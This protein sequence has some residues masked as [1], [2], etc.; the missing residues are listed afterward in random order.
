M[1]PPCFR[2]VLASDEALQKALETESKG[3]LAERAQTCG[4]FF[5]GISWEEHGEYHGIDDIS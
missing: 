1:F 3:D 5:M 4:G 2:Q